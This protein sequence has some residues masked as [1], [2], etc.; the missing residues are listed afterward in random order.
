MKMKKLILSILLFIPL[1]FLAKSISW[2]DG[3]Q[4][5]YS[6]Q[7]RYDPVVGKALAMFVSDMHAVTGCRAKEKSNGRVMVWQLDRMSNKEF[8]ALDDLSV[9]YS[10]VIAKPDAFWMGV[11]KGKVVVV[12]S[13]GRGTAYGL[14]ELSRQAGVSPW[15]WWGDVVPQRCQQLVMDETFETLQAPSVDVRG[16][17][18][19]NVPYKMN[20]HRLFELLLR[21]RANALWP[22]PGEDQDLPHAVS[23]TADS[24]AISLGPVRKDASEHSYFE[25]DGYGYLLPRH[26]DRHEKDGAPCGLYYHLSYKGE[27]HPYL[28]LTTMQPGLI[29]QQLREAYQQGAT[30]FWII[31]VHDPKVAAYDL[32]LCMDMAWNIQSVQP[33]ATSQHLLGWLSEQFGNEVGRQLLQPMRDFYRLTAI[34]HPEFMANME[35]E[36]SADE[37]G[38]EL[39]YYLKGY[40]SVVR[41]VDAASRSLRQELQDAY[42][43][44]IQYPVYVA[45]A[46]A[47]KH[48]EAQEARV[49]ARGG[50][51]HKDDEALESAVK[52][53]LAYQDIKKLTG[54]YNKVMS[55]GKWRGT[56]N[57]AP[58]GLSVFDAPL[59]PDQLAEEEIERFAGADDVPSRLDTDNCIVRNGTQYDI[60]SG[61]VE[62][63]DMMGH[64]MQAVVIPPG[65]SVVYRFESRSREA[66]L[67]TAFIPVHGLGGNDAGYRDKEQREGRPHGG[68]QCVAISIDGGTPFVH[69]L[70]EERLSPRWMVNVLRG[71]AVRSD[72]IRIATG[73]HTLIV[74]ALDEGIIL[75]QWMIDDDED[76]QF[77]VFPIQ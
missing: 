7:K 4:V 3:L 30:R 77:Y 14:L 38:N 20:Y 5:T 52:S 62:T 54:Q 13:N 73:R 59:L 26:N 46:M 69:D 17:A 39:E 75:D 49:I 9:P 16:L 66:V 33:G 64:S 72:D 74:K 18:L 8:K 2:M 45:A 15:V 10:K 67:R 27:P 68:R 23:A 60:A 71:Q 48:L 36:F 35:T 31:D 51:F 1:P 42:F 32:S 65:D 29:A 6:L 25:D 34:R 53:W 24:F 12:G 50:N 70:H 43:A 61:G 47:T 22:M 28:W 40:R 37:F 44:A 63:I 41:Q 58:G 21:L 57:M 55:G 56:M 76:R 19:S 11:R